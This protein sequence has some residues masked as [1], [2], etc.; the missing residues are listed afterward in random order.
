VVPEDRLE[1][2]TLLGAAVG[3]DLRWPA[4]A[5]VVVLVLRAI[6]RRRRVR[7]R[8]GE[9]WFARVPFE[10]GTASKDRPVLVLSVDGRTSTVARF[11]SQDKGARRDHLRVP[12]GIPGLRR[13]SWVSLL[14]V[15]LRRS[16]MRRLAGEPGA[17]LVQWYLDAAGSPMPDRGEDDTVPRSESLAASETRCPVREVQWP[18]RRSAPGRGA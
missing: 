2:D 18:M 5:L 9:I 12:E 16:A 6:A 3:D 15:R 4:A 17:P 10:D 8:T 1:F 13:D 7:P 11:T 14:P